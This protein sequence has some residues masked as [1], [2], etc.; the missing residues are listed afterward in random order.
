MCYAVAFQSEHFYS[1]Y[2]LHDVLAFIKTY[3]VHVGSPSIS[4]NL[5]IFE[6]KNFM[7]SEIE[8]SHFTKRLTS[9]PQS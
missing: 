4:V 3:D 6:N 2:L 7:T 9:K 1:I 8:N 5:K